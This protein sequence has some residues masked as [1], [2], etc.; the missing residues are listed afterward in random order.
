MKEVCVHGHFYQPSRV[1]PWTGELRPQPSAAPFRD[2]NERIAAE[3]YAPSL[4]ARILDP[5][6]RTRRLV[7]TCAWGSFD[8]GPT[9]LAWLEEHRPV[10]LE[11]IRR[12]DRDSPA[13][14]PAGPVRQLRHHL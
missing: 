6:G 10:V 8:F 13:A 11:G 3:C 14:G 2:W 4:S 1:D 5:Q 9:L 12:A 7:N